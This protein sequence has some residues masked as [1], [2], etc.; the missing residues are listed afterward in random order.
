MVFKQYIMMI[1][2][3]MVLVRIAMMVTIFI[4]NVFIDYRIIVRPGL[5]NNTTSDSIVRAG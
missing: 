4:P 2:S 5:A 3:Y 1:L